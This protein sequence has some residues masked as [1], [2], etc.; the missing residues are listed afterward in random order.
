[1]AVE[2]APNESDLRAIADRNAI[3]AIRCLAAAER[4]VEEGRLNVAKVLRAA[5]LSSRARALI[6]ERSLA[7]G[8]QSTALITTLADS[9]DCEIDTLRRMNSDVAGLAGDG[10]ESLRGIVATTAQSLERNRD[11]LESEVAQ[12][13]WGCHECGF[14]TQAQRPEVCPACGSIAGDFELFAPFFSST[15]ERIARRQPAEIVEMLRRAPIALAESLAAATDDAL[16]ARPST[17]EWCAAEIAGHMIDIAELFCRRLRS[18]LAPVEPAAPERSPLPWKLMEGQGYEAMTAETLT[19]RFSAAIHGA[20]AMIEALDER[21][22]S[23]RVE[24][25][26]GKVTVLDMGSWLANH[27]VAHQAQIAALREDA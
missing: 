16:R 18:L 8:T 14:I 9:L 11:V 10:A 22:W 17:D 3:L 1:V 19:G 23:S 21:A 26:S 13:V 5:A 15:S 4:A 27:N 24:L 7:A 20:L 12:F 6:I 25:V 2:V